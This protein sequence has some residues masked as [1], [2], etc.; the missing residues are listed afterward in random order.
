MDKRLVEIL[1]VLFSAMISNVGLHV[2][3]VRKMLTTGSQVS[4]VLFFMAV[5]FLDIRMIIFCKSVL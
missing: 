4:L 3:L 2:G 1:N 5:C